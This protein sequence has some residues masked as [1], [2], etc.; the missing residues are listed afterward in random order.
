VAVFGDW[1]G[2]K[3]AQLEGLKFVVLLPTLLRK[4]TSPPAGRV[5]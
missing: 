1:I 3:F 2:P 5:A 4:I